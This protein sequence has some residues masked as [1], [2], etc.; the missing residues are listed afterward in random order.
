MHKGTLSCSQSNAQGNV[1]VLP[2]LCTRER[3]RVHSLMHKGT[4]SCSQYNAQ[5]NVIVFTVLCT[6][7]RYRVHSLMHK[8]TV[9][10]SQSYAQGNVIVFAVLAQPQNGVETM[11]K[12]RPIIIYWWVPAIFSISYHIARWPH[13]SL[14]PVYRDANY[15]RMKEKFRKGS[16]WLQRAERYCKFVQA[17]NCDVI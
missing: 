2:V 11:G 13:N 3:Y 9:S 4:L 1:I 8:G 5:L 10:C 16:L 15:I 7:E 17:G 14:T 12:L 6:R